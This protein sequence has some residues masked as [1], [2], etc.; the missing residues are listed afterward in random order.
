MKY[1]DFVVS[2]VHD[3]RVK[4]RMDAKAEGRRVTGSFRVFVPGELIL[5]LD[6]VSVGLCVGGEGYRCGII[7]DIKEMIQEVIWSKHG[8]PGRP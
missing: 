7:L 6:G 5:A 3:P 1:F 4:E 8:W 2:E